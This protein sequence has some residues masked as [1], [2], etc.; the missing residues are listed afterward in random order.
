M[1]NVKQFNRQ[2]AMVKGQKKTQIT[3]DMLK[4]QSATKVQPRR[5]KNTGRGAQRMKIR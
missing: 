2:R 1:P 5:I 4:Q 3:I